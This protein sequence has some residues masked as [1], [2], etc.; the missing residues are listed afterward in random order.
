MK[1]L[2]TKI[3]ETKKRVLAWNPRFSVLSSSAATESWNLVLL[4]IETTCCYLQDSNFQ[5]RKK[6]KNFTSDKKSAGRRS[7]SIIIIK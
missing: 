4:E 1:G 3:S 2:F 5:E 7:V 6:K